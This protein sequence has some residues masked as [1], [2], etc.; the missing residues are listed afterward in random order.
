MAMRFKKPWYVATK[1]LMQGALNEASQGNFTPMARLVAYSVTV[2]AGA[3]YMKDIIK[4]SG[5]DEETRQMLSSGDYG[6]A[7][8]RMFVDV[9]L[10][11]NS[12]A[13]GIRNIRE[14]KAGALMQLFGLVGQTIY[15][16]GSSGIAGEVLPINQRSQS[17]V[18]RF[19]SFDSFKPI[20]VQSVLRVLGM[21]GALINKMGGTLTPEKANADIYEA[22]RSEVI[23]ARR[24]FDLFNAKPDEVRA[25]EDA[26]KIKIENAKVPK[27]LPTKERNQILEGVATPEK[28]RR[29]IRNS[30]K[31]GKKL[32]L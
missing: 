9:P 26:R 23:P 1:T 3:Q 22:F 32:K 7:I 24:V 17:D 6:G 5:L 12:L 21:G 30:I 18:R 28:V 10:E 19:D 2:G 27:D 25:R 20:S 15:E 16:S 11:K 8:K 13:Q 4:M 31:S 14:D 29:S